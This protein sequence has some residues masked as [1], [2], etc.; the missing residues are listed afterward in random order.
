MAISENSAIQ[1]HAR[2][3]LHV[4][5]TPDHIF[6]CPTPR[7]AIIIPRRDFVSDIDMRLCAH[8]AREL[9]DADAET[10]ADA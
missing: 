3:A 2:T 8:V 5:E 9:C 6:L 4:I 1:H 10:A 7:D